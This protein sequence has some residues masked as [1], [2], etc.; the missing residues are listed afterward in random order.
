MPN[1][2]QRPV[3][4]DVGALSKICVFS[5]FNDSIS[6]QRSMDS[7]VGIA[8]RYGLNGP[9]IESRCGRDFPHLS[10]PALRPTQPPIQCVPGLSRGHRGRGLA[11]TRNPSSAEV[12]ERVA[13]PLLPLW[14]FVACSRMK[15]TCIFVNCTGYIAFS[16]RLNVSCVEHRT[17]M[18]V[19]VTH[20]QG[21][22][23]GK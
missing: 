16:G 8:T 12:K 7:S 19:I 6:T 4:F 3:S 10:R 23:P 9:G 1:D 21:S 22:L 5:S 13:I 2:L 18:E 15:F 11:L 14:A 20:L 17:L